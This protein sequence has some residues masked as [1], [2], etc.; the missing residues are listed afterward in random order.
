MKALKTTAL[1]I[2]CITVLFSCDTDKKTSIKSGIRISEV[3]LPTNY[4]HK[5]IQMDYEYAINTGFIIPSANQTNNGKFD[6][7]FI[8]ENETN[9]EHEYFYKI[10]YQNESYKWPVVNPLDNTKQH[11]FRDFILQFYL[12]YR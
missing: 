12:L 11:E 1:F 7:D 9:T 5:Q 4:L 2:I 6:F 10:Y 3:H 8:I